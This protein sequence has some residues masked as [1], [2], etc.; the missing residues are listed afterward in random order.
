MGAGI[1]FEA[2]LAEVGFLGAVCGCSAAGTGSAGLDTEVNDLSVASE[3][4][5]LCARSPSVI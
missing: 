2:V 1:S 5:R 4:E 3:L